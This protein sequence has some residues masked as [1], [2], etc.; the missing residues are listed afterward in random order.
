M[1]LPIESHTYTHTNEYVTNTCTFT[2]Y[3]TCTYNSVVTIMT[4]S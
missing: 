4:T 3:G 2:R 1:Y